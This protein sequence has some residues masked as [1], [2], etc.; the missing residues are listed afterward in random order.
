VA[1]SLLVTG[2][3]ATVVALAIFSGASIPYQD[4]PPELLVRQADEI[5]DA[6]TLLVVGLVAIA[7]GGLALWRS[8]AGDGEGSED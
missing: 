8:R 1:I 6:G 7:V 2:L 3:G 4:A 5:R